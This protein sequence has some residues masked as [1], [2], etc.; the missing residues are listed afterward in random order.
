[1]EQIASATNEAGSAMDKFG[2]KSERAGNKASRGS[3][4]TL[5]VAK[6]MMTG[7]VFFQAFTLLTEGVTTGL[8]HMALANSQANATMSALATNSLYLKDS[9]AAALMPAIQAS[10][11][12]INLL[13]ECLANVFN[14]IGM[15]TARIFGHAKTVTIAK[16]SYVDYAKTISESGNNAAEVAAKEADK[17]AK[18]A[19]QNDK[20]AAAADKHNKK[21]KELKRTIM[22]F[23][24]IN[25]LQDKNKGEVQTPT[26]KTPDYSSIKDN[27]MPDPSTEFETVKIPG[28]ID[29][30]GGMTD[31]VEK[32]IKG[33]WDGLTDKQKWAAKKGATA[34]FVIGGIIGGLLFGKKGILLGAGI[35]AGAGAFIGAWWEK[36]TT[37]EKWRVGIGAS[38][39]GIIGG[40]I[41]AIIFKNPKAFLAGALIGSGVGAL[42]ADWWGKLTDSQKWS[43]GIGAGA[44]SIIGGI[45]GGILTDGNPIGIAVGALLLGTIGGIIGDWWSGL[46]DSQKWQY[47]I[48]AGA[49]ATV[50]GIIGGILTGGN[51]IGIAVGA[52]LG[53]TAGAIISDLWGKLTDSQRWGVGIG[54]TAGTVIGGIIGTIICPG[55][56]TALGA[57]LGGAGGIA[58]GKFWTDMTQKEKWSAGIGAGAGAII[59]GIIGTLICPGIGTVLGGLLGSAGGTVIGKFWANM[60]TNQKWKVGAGATAGT[61]IGTII[62]TL[63]CPGIG[64][65]LGALLGGAGGTAIATFWSTMTKK[66]QWNAGIGA[67]AG[68]V[69]GGIIGTI[70]C[71]GIGTVLGAMLG[72][73]AGSIV[74]KF[75]DDLINNFKNYGAQ[76]KAA[77]S[78]DWKK[79]NWLQKHDTTDPDKYNAREENG[80]SS[81]FNKSGTS[82]HPGGPAIVND[83][84]GSTYREL[85]QYPNGK[86]FIPDGRNVLIPDLPVGTKIFP[87]DVTQRMIPHYAKGTVDGNSALQATQQSITIANVFNVDGKTDSSILGESGAKVKQITDNLRTSADTRKKIVSDETDYTAKKYQE[88]SASLN[89]SVPTLLKGISANVSDTSSA[90]QTDTNTKW[91][92]ISTFLDGKFSGISKSANTNFSAAKS[93]EQSNFASAERDVSSK[94]SRMY[95]NA[96]G[97]FKAI[98]SD[99]STY[100]SKVKQS[101]QIYM[102]DSDNIVNQHSKAINNNVAD[103]I[104]GAINGVVAG[105]N[106]VLSA[107]GSKATV[108]PISIKRYAY[109]SGHHPG[110]AALVN[111][112]SG[113]TYRELVQLPSGH[114]FIPQGRNVLIPDLPAGS[115]VLPAKQTKQMFPH[116]ANGVGDF[117]GT[118]KAVLDTFSTNMWNYLDKPEMLLHA[119]VDK[120]TAMQ[121]INFPW[122]EM[123][124]STVQFLTSHSVDF[125]KKQ[126]AEFTAPGNGTV[127]A[128]LKIAEAE[129]GYLEKGSNSS[130]DDKAA[131]A[132]HAD[133]TKFGRDF[134]MNGAAWC[135]MFVSWCLK[136]AGVDE[137][138]SASCEDSMSHFKS[139]NRWTNNPARGDLIFYDWDKNGTADHIGIVESIASGLVNTIE[140]NTSGSNGAEGVFRKRRNA[141]SGNILGYGIPHF[142]S[143]M[144]AAISAVAN[145]G[146]GVEQWRSLAS[147]AL[148]MT[149]HYST[150]NVDLLLSQMRTESDG[151]VDPPDLHDVNY[152]AG[153]PSKGLM[154]LIPE[155]FSTYAL[156]GYNTNI[157]DPLSNIIASIRYTWA[158]Y[159][160]PD[161]VWGQG[162]GYAKGIGNID[163]G[164]WNAN[165]GIY[166]APTLIGIGEKGKE[167]ALPMRKESYAEIAQG[168]AEQQTNGNSANSSNQNELVN[169]VGAILAI[170]QSNSGKPI[171][172]HVTADLDGK[173]IY[174][175]TQNYKAIDS[176]R[177]VPTH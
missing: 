21:L 35:G 73:T 83:A 23:D 109:G 77:L 129:L 4:S 75:W 49:G 143:A 16:K 141:N 98:S 50:G 25:A 3:N 89:N 56:G 44:G 80:F 5:T 176:R 87:A 84:P 135:D 157:L 97:K 26:I 101:A 57:L 125:I 72:N 171:Q 62:G 51:P 64:T 161:G 52:L 67:T 162:H 6:H 131:N 74:G 120:S 145:V 124:R 156:P 138:L 126:L 165:G 121:S 34:G 54:A 69:I 133:F 29:K 33:W 60:T 147:K 48:G 127:E 93:F 66:Q 82:S 123:E 106:S 76:W 119:A 30:I 104:G 163:W 68:T 90:I 37:P 111:D 41:G 46:T 175:S 27:G 167:A 134:G 108:K 8:Q 114:A 159:G 11:P 149:G 17:A 177:Y 99:A 94:T 61:V 10:I 154:Q 40:I 168:I 36:L 103:K 91:N 20:S 1:M 166:D 164:G 153:H 132:G 112:Q 169:Q 63:I 142:K 7:M 65:K 42:I 136:R 115:S 158:R 32:F 128:F 15:L 55:I 14:T 9:I 172:L 47:G 122:N 43:T 137:Y 2:N 53:G 85:I 70:I 95:S 152:Y 139:A 96:S 92:G 22:G 58:A 146:S 174:D 150:H 59:G 39:G 155:T 24:E 79:L 107:V 78:G 116:Y 88:I 118:S 102:S 19:A 31:Q 170:L 12:L 144:E 151:Q 81:I 110:G 148:M 18:V 173:S 71:P 28:W 45:V 105:I 160:S 86:K 13:S 130:L 38:V 113:S 117:F 100:F 140:G